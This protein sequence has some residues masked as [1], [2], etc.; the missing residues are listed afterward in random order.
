MSNEETPWRSLSGAF[1]L[2][3]KAKVPPAVR[4][5]HPETPADAGLDRPAR[6]GRRTALEPG[7]QD[8][9]APVYRSDDPGYATGQVQAG[10]LPLVRRQQKMS[11]QLTTPDPVI[12]RDSGSHH[13]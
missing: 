5:G 9:I 4:Q 6:T 3:I 2:G 11:Q 12:P 13:G 10:F 7:G 8:Q 1:L